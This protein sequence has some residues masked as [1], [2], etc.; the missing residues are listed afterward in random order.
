M[1]YVE[2]HCDRQFVGNPD[3]IHPIC[4][5]LGNAN[6]SILALSWNDASARAKLEAD[7]REVGWVKDGIHWIC[8]DCFEHERT[9][10]E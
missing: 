4:C 7:A 10:P 8:P 6:P 9:A 3:A 2:I 1:I 5:T